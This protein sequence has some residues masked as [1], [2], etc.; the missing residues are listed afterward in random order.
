MRKLLTITV[1]IFTVVAL[2]VAAGPAQ[3]AR[4]KDVANIK[5][6]RSNQLIGY[7][8]VVGLNGTGDDQQVYFTLRSVQLLLRRLGV[9]AAEDKV[10][11]LRNLRLRNAAAVMVTAELPPFVRSGTKIDVVVSAMGNATSL[12]GGTLLMTPLRG[13]DLKV[14]ALSQGPLSIGG[15]SVAG[16]TGSS[17]SKNHTTVGRI[18]SGAII[19]RE[20]NSQFITVEKKKKEDQDKNKKENKD[21]KQEEKKQEAN[22]KDKKDDQEKK[23]KKQQEEEE[24]SFMVVALQRPDF[25]T[26]FRI[27]EAINKNLDEKVANSSDPATVVV[28]VPKS[29]KGKEVELISRL[30][31]VEVQPDAPAQVIVNERTGTVVVGQAVRLSPVAIAHGSLTLEV[32]EKFAVSQPGAAFGAGKTE[33]VP[34]SKVKATEGQGPIQLIE[35]GATLADVVKALNALGASPRDLVAILQALETAGALPAKLVVQ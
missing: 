14:Y 19:E 11:D 3:A 28:D 24:R 6:I 2:N 30:E 12:Q 25:T 34:R 33:V 26:A 1:A 5:G 31:L 16:R 15:F 21:K 29:Y 27:V 18:P 7:G 10:F 20:V 9:Q 23:D 17:V 8:L 22:V 13:V 4:L 35:G 32:S